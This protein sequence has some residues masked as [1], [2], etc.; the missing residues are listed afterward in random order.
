MFLILYIQIHVFKVHFLN[1]FSPINVRL[2]K[3]W[4]ILENKTENEQ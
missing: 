1:Y 4:P 2:L 3:E